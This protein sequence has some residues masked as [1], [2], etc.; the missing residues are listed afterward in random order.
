MIPA[1]VVDRTIAD[2]VT[3]LEAKDLLIEDGNSCYVNDIGRAK[4]LAWRRIHQDFRARS[5]V[6]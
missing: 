1:A 3:R 2:L 4:E 6:V 5:Q